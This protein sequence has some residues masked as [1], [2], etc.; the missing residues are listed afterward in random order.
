MK[1]IITLNLT[2]VIVSALLIS[3]C[4]KP[5]KANTVLEERIIPVNVT[6]VTSGSVENRINFLGD[7]KAYREVNVYSTIPEK[8]TS[9]NVDVNDV[10]QKGDILA[11]VNDVKIRQGVLQAEAGLASAKA[12]YENISTEWDRIQKLYKESAVSKSQYDAVRTQ[13]EAAEAAVKQLSAGLKSAK[14]QLADTKIKAPISGIISARNYN[15][16][17][18]TSS[19]YPAFTIIDMDTVKIYIDIVEYQVAQIKEGQKAL[20]RV[21]G[22]PNKVFEGVVAK[23][24]PTLNPLSRSVKAEIVI[25]NEDLLLKPGMY[26]NVDVITD[27]KDNVPVI[28]PYCIIKKTNLEYLGG[29]VSNTRVKTEKYVYV[30]REDIAYQKQIATGIEE[31]NAIEIINGINIGD[32]IVTRGQYDLSDSTLVRIIEKGN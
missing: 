10:V 25:D 14:E 26:A 1:R 28:P 18:Q 5:N 16:G 32:V 22:Y 30:I 2:I 27:C 9:L 6:T 20:I 3:N 13:K 8:I 11:T 24:Y 31:A 12:Q 4:G 21:N 19:Q 17:D 23:V 29:E 7:I 15:F